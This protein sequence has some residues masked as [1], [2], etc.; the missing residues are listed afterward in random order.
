MFRFPPE[1]ESMLTSA[2]LSWGDALWPETDYNDADDATAIWWDPDATG[3]DEAGNEGTGMIRY[4][5]RR[6]ALPPG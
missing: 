4:V 5:D 6:R 3:Q 2:H 1:T